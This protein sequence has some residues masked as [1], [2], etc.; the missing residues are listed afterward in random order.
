MNNYGITP[1]NKKEKIILFKKYQ[2]R[3][4]T[5]FLVALLLP[6]IVVSLFAFD[7]IKSRAV[8]GIEYGVALLDAGNGSVGTSFRISETKMLTAKHVVQGLKA[9]DD[10]TVVFKKF[11]P[12]IETVAKVLFVPSESTPL[13]DYAVLELLEIDKLEEVPILL[14]GVS[15]TVVQRDE[16]LAIGYPM[17]NSENKIT[18]GIIT[19]NTFS[20][21]DTEYDLFDTNCDVDNGNSGGPLLMK[22]SEEVIGIMIMVNEGNHSKANLA[23]KVDMVRSEL[24]KVAPQIN[25]EE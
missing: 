5:A 14:L 4:T 8:I 17:N 25:L 11:E 1:N 24:L 13:K 21:N 19:A 9:G 20:L 16:V 15:E 23:L 6:F 10:V 2:K 18:D 22:T 7:I 3:N 12:P